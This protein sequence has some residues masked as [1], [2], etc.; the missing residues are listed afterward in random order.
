MALGQVG[1]R[2][3]GDYY[4]GLFFWW[5]AAKLLLDGSLVRRVILEHD[6]ADGVDD[7]AVFY[8][9]PGV[10][11][12][13]WLAS[14]DFYQLKHHVDHR[15]VY[16]A[17]ALIAQFS[18]A[19]SSLLQ[20]FQA[21]NDSLIGEG[22]TSFRLHLVSNWSWSEDCPLRAVI[23]ADGALRDEFFTA[24]ARSKLGNKREAWRA[25][26]KMTAPAFTEFARRLRFDVNFFGRKAFRDWVSERLHAAGLQT[27]SDNRRSC[28][29]ESLVARFLM[30]GTNDFDRDS[31]K[32]LCTNEGLMQ[33]DLP[34]GK[35]FISVGVR[36]FLRFAEN[37]ED[38]CDEFICLAANFEGRHPREIASWVTVA[39][40][41]RTYFADANRR[42]RLLADSAAI[43]LEC[44]GSIAAL[45]GYELS[46]NS[47]IAVFPLQKGRAGPSLW[48][49]QASDPLGPDDT[50]VSSEFVASDEEGALVVT[51]SITHDVTRDVLDYISVGAIGPVRRA[52]NLTPAN[53][54]GSG[55]VM[56]PTHADCLV[57]QLV[58]K[59]QA[60]RSRRSEAIHLFFAAPNAVMFT[61]G[62]RREALGRVQFYEFDLGLTAHG[63]Y[64]PSIT[65]PPT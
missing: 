60:L 6:V 44:H 4:Q 26:L 45:V 25:H 17:D 31:M 28:P 64:A 65:L 14:A 15:G 61:L 50:W 27:P 58:A 36:S 5:Q 37:M 29:F 46:T 20:R 49:P 19:K 52:V 11:A 7:V 21:A 56:G 63:T 8:E 23:G 54:H 47:G 40:D 10:D 35:E 33:K 2:T 43:G 12:G 55:S 34:P 13:G 24:G 32:A 38:S 39:A 1:A 18:G 3:E 57:D 62:R 59:M 51:L 9:A 16:S 22:H 30:D 42:S 48:Q 41:V 53:G